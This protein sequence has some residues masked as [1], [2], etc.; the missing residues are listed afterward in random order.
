MALET[1]LPLLLVLGL[2]LAGAQKALEEVPVQ[3]GFDAH[4]VEGHWLTLQLAASRAELVSPSDPLRL[5]L[6]SIR[7]SDSGDVDFVLFWKGE[8]VCQEKRITVHPTQLQGQYQGSCECP[9]LS[10][11]RAGL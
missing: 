5:A 7:T 2:G 10:G 1:A 9:S 6:H 3:R 4:K 11:I 8:G